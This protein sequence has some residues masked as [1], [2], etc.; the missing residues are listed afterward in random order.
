MSSLSL[1]SSPCLW[2]RVTDTGLLDAGFP[3]AFGVFQQYYMTHE[4]FAGQLSSIAA[5]GTT[6][7]V[8]L[9]QSVFF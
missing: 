4:P 7:T 5:I 3:L 8:S 2:C 9:F 6:S 1:A